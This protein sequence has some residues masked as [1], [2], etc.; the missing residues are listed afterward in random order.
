MLTKLKRTATIKSSDY[1]GCA[2]LNKK[3]V[4]KLTGNFPHIVRQFKSNFTEYTDPK[5]H[6][7]RL[8]LRNLHYLK[9]LPDEVINELI[10]RM[11][12]KRFAIGSNIIKSGDVSNVSQIVLIL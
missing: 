6:F 4:I 3:D 12:V 2:F 5:M 9:K 1:S 10:C 8:M 11:E 7:R